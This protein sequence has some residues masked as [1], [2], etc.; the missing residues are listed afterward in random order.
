MKQVKTIIF[1]VIA[2][3][4]IVLTAGPG[5]AERESAFRF[6]IR[7]FNDG[8]YRIAVRGFRRFINSY[9]DDERLPQAQM[10]KAE[11]LLHL[12]DYER[13]FDLLLRLHQENPGFEPGLVLHRLAYLADQLGRESAVIDLLT[14]ENLENRPVLQNFLIKWKWARGEVD[15]L[16]SRFLLLDAGELTESAQR[17]LAQHELDRETQELKD[18]L[19]AGRWTPEIRDNLGELPP[20]LRQNLLTLAARELW[21]QE[22]PE[23]LLRL[24]ERVPS[25]WQSAEMALFRAES[26]LATGEYQVAEDNYRFL[27][28]AGQYVAQ[29]TYGLAWIKYDRDQL[30]EA[31]TL[32]EEVDWPEVGGELAAG[33]SRLKGKAYMTDG[34]FEEATSAYQDAVDFSTDEGFINET[35]YWL[36]WN[37]YQQGQVEAAYETFMQVQSSEK[38]PVDELYRIRGRTAMELGDYDT[39]LS[40]YERALE[41]VPDGEARNKTEYE[42]AQL[43]YETGQVAESFD[44]LL[45]LSRR[46]LTAELEPAVNFALGRSALEMGRYTLAWSVFRNYETVLEQQF[47]VEFAYFTGEAAY[48][49]GQYE[50]ARRYYDRVAADFPESAFASAARRMSFRTELEDLDPESDEQVQRIRKKI[51]ASPAAEQADMTQGWAESLFE[52][53]ELEEAEKI[54]RELPEMTDDPIIVAEAIN[55]VVDIRLQ[56]NQ[57]LEALVYLEE[58]L[59]PV[60]GHEHLVT[61]FY[62]L[63]S[64]L[65]NFREIDELLEWGPKFIELY[66][67]SR[68]HGEVH[69][70]LGEGKRLYDQLQQAAESYEKSIEKAVRTNIKLRAQFRLAQ[71]SLELENYEKAES[72][73][74]EVSEAQ[75]DFV[76]AD[77]IKSLQAEVA[78]GRED[79]SLA[80][81]LIEE[82]ES[83]APADQL[84]SARLFYHGGEYSRANSV[85]E[86]MET[87]AAADLQAQLYFWKG[88]VARELNDYEDA[89]E[90]WYHVYYVYEDWQEREK[91]IYEL[92]GLAE[93]LG[94]ES[95]AERLR[96]LLEEEYPESP[97]LGSS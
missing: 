5:L 10:W 63:L 70:M 78:Y 43:Y 12:E 59:E 66:E 65:Y 39:A 56:F 46:E 52:L 64:G 45:E 16:V 6:P 58:N 22:R 34:R 17:L 61:G 83:P 95:E 8:N 67:T 62:R 21:E 7:A 48:R 73:L 82:I 88:R 41:T 35:R 74:G 81:Q 25:R 26:A 77:E 54:Y 38:I 57:P 89:E 69:F 37:Y 20:G 60:A 3:V 36:G 94:E 40:A 53:G 87:P 96:Q 51:E 76:T 18:D 4:L 2:A 50:R 42:L 30:S 19:A 29:A 86:E 1:V 68:Y 75:P 23:D 90:Y 24:T 47:P 84:L 91:V 93:E 55:Q 31:Y 71:V 11:A 32:L 80:R 92:K 49:A 15:S 44:L 33:A 72:L 85:L 79:F 13:S 27:Q 9:P 14:T 28:D 97:L